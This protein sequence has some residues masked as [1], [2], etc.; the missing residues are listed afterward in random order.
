[1]R[2]RR[3]VLGMTALVALTVYNAEFEVHW[4]KVWLDK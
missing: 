1:M 4:E 2:V 3:L